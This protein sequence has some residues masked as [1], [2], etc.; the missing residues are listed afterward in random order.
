[1]RWNLPL[2]AELLKETLL[3]LSLREMVVK[4]GMNRRKFVA[5]VI[6][7]D[8]EDQEDW[9]RQQAVWSLLL[10]ELTEDQCEMVLFVFTETPEEYENLQQEVKEIESG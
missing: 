4:V 8:Y 7:P 2:N 10:N 9:Q 1:M 5:R 6:S 3:K